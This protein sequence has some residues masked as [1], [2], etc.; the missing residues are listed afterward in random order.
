[1]IWLW[2][3]LGIAVLGIGVFLVIYFVLAPKNLF[4]TFV[5]EGTSKVVVRG[6]KF[7][8]ALIQW[9]G[10]TLN[11]D[12]EVVGGEEKQLFFGGLMF[13]GWWPLDDIYI[14]D[15][16]WTSIKENGE[17]QHHEKEVLDYILLK[18][19]VYW[20]KVEKAEDMQMLPLDVE[21]ILSIR[22]INPYKA[23]FA[24]EN[25]LEAVINRIRPAVRNV[26]TQ[27]VYEELIRD[28]KAIGQKIKS[29]LQR[30]EIKDFKKTY[31]VELREVAVK[32]INPPEDYREET[33]RKYVAER[34]RDRIETEADAET[35]RIERVYKA[36][37][38]FGD[39]GRLIRTLE[40]LEKSPKE[41]AKWVI[42][43][44]GGTEF[45][46]GVF[47]KAPESVTPQEIKELREMVEK[48]AGDLK[49]ITRRK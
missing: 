48:M 4:W 5:Q 12:W 26:I 36:V 9:K 29:K 20:T 31:G 23:L 16:T 22:V 7:K 17:P 13:Y 19:D 11:D 2:I 27:G 8:Q 25:W 46:R 44:P 49:K 37:Q 43:L 42:P 15:F 10:Y 28:K 14:Y 34:A 40:A 3:L 41:G 18:E 21:L 30:K 35:L 33:L 47:G 6:D 1:M 24:I 39:L 38:G 32:D 45:L